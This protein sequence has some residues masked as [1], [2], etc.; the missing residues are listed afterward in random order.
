MVEL[1]QDPSLKPVWDIL[2]FAWGPPEATDGAAAATDDEAP[3]LLAIEDGNVGSDDEGTITTT[4]PEQTSDRVEPEEITLD[5]PDFGI[6]GA[7]AHHVRPEDRVHE[8]AP[9]GGDHVAGAVMVEES[10]PAFE[11]PD[12]QVDDPFPEYNDCHLGTQLDDESIDDTMDKSV[13]T[14]G[15]TDES[16]DDTMDKTDESM[17]DT[18]D[19]T[20]ETMDKTDDLMDKSVDTM[21]KTDDTMDKSADTMDKTD[22]TIGKNAETMDKTEKTTDD[23]GKPASSDAMPP[24]PPVSPDHMRRKRE[25]QAKMEELRPGFVLSC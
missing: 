8:P 20:D 22:D 25:I 3:R 21:D 13:D 1:P 15:K 23:S 16:M 12:S 19:K 7:L 2:D 18:M 17:D 5:H 24:P 11:E 6:Y 9:V 10:Q 4:E 14:M